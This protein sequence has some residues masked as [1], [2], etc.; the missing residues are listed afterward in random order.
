M[1]DDIAS[2]LNG[3]GIRAIIENF[4]EGDP[5][6]SLVIHDDRIV[7]HFVHAVIPTPA[8][9]LR[10]KAISMGYRLIAIHTLDWMRNPDAIKAR[11]HVVFH[12]GGRIHADRAKIHDVSQED[13]ERFF[14]AYH[15]AGFPK[16]NDGIDYKTVGLFKGGEYIA[17]MLFAV[18]NVC[19]HGHLIDCYATKGTV[20]GG[21]RML[22]E[23]YRKHHV[24]KPTDF[25][26]DS[27]LNWET[28]GLYYSLG[29][30]PDCE[31]E[32]ELNWQCGWT[33]FVLK[34]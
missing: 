5:Q 32:P 13:A 14:D 19:Y 34:P 25:F 28:G 3:L 22:F 18:E 30:E 27:D 15:P 11:L 10:N 1:L 7:I 21:G 33:K 8:H 17:M 31:I 12:T 23:Y 6:S 9:Y 2:F 26:V 29:F 4:F 24:P 16:E 20:I